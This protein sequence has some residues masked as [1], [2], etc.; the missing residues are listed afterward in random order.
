M[1]ALTLAYFLSVPVAIHTT[2]DMH[3]TFQDILGGFG[4]QSW[5]WGNDPNQYV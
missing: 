5:E 1:E 3:P 4:G 2:L